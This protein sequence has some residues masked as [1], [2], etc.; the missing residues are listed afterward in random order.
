MSQKNLVLDPSI[1]TSQ[2]HRL[3]TRSIKLKGLAQIKALYP[4][5][6]TRL[7][8]TL[9]DLLQPEPNSGGL[10]SESCPGARTHTG[11]LELSSAFFSHARLR[12]GDVGSLFLWQK[13]L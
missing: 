5:L 4:Y 2:R 3:F 11:R 10:N 12:Y 7:G 1:V 13:P 9:Q 6:E 8:S